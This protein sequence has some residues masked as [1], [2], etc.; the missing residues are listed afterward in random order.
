M[1]SGGSD[2]INH[3]WLIQAEFERHLRRLSVDRGLVSGWEMDLANQQW[4]VAGADRDTMAFFS[5]GH[6]L[7]QAAVVDALGDEGGRATKA[8]MRQLDSRAKRQ[9]T[10]RKGDQQLTWAQIRDRM[11]ARANAAGVDLTSAFAGSSPSMV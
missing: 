9:V 6:A 3:A 1:G 8:R 2:F 10:G 4:E 11:L 7:V 5:Q